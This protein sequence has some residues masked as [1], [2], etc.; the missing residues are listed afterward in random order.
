MASKSCSCGRV[1]VT[2]FLA[3]AIALGVG[4]FIAYKYV[5]KPKLDELNDNNQPV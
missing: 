2:S 3:F 5:I 4:G 1:F